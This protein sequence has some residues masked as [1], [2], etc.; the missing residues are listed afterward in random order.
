[1]GFNE[2]IAE[3]PGLTIEGRQ[4]PVRRTLDLLAYFVS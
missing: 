4:I 1:M 2:V 3:L